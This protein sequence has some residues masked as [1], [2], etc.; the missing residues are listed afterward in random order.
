MGERLAMRKNINHQAKD[1]DLIVAAALILGLFL[2]IG[3][4][5]FTN[6][7]G[8][9]FGPGAGLYIFKG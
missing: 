1:R 4:G 2:A 7:F 8:S 5:L 3:V 9:W 6:N